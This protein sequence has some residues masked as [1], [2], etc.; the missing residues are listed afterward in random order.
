MKNTF[1]LV[2][3]IA[4]FSCV[5]SKSVSSNSVSNLDAPQFSKVIS[6]VKS[7]I[8]IDVRTPEEF[9]QGHISGAINVNWNGEDFEKQ[10][11]KFPKTETIY[12][13]CLSGGRS[14]SAVS[15][16]S[17][18][19][20]LKI[21]E[22]NGGIMA[23]RNASLPE[24]KGTKVA[25]NDV[26][27]EKYNELIASNNEI[28]I[29]FYAVWCPPCQKQEPVLEAFNKQSTIKTV[30]INLD[31]NPVLCKQLGVTTLPVLL[32]F[33]NGKEIWKKTKFVDLEELKLLVKDS[34]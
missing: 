7:P 2:I 6:E 27:L 33:K 32:Y 10:M 24:E 21:T 14:A 15:F 20:Y 5:N 19:G 34:I 31:E 11:I 4:L 26:S 23:W 30:R 28:I 22:L 16:L 1:Y 9:D 3:L 29:D 18:K 12:L 17:E 25:K 8:L 13:Y